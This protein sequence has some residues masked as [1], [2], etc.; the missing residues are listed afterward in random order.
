[1]ASSVNLDAMLPR[2]DF[3]VTA[4]NG[5]SSSKIQTIGLKDLTS[6][7]FIVPALRKPD[8]QRE[9]NHWSPKQISVFLK[10]FLEGELIPSLILWK[11]D[12]YIFVI[13][14]G[15]RISALRA[16][17]ED[18]YGDGPQSRLFYKNQIPAEQAKLAAKTRKIVN[19]EIGSYQE[20]VSVAKNIDKHSDFK[21]ILAKNMPAQA[22]PLL[23]VEGDADKAESSFFKINTQGT[24]LDKI[25]ERLLKN[26]RKPAA[27]A[28]RSLVRAGTGHKYWSKFEHEKK[29]QIE[30]VSKQLFE[31]LFEPETTEPLK[32]LDLPL[33]GN[34]SYGKSLDLIIDY[35]YN[36]QPT[37][38]GEKVSLEKMSDDVD[39]NLTLSSLY[40]CK[41]ITERI[42][43]NSHG[44]LGLHPAIYFYNHMGKPNKF[45]FLAVTK[46]FADAVNNNDA[47]FFKKFTQAREKLEKFLIAHKYL[48]AHI[49]SQTRSQKRISVLEGVFKFC[50]EE[51][52]QE[53][54]LSPEKI[55]D[56]AGLEFALL[57]DKEAS[58][59][60]ISTANKN[61]AFLSQALN[62]ALICPIC[63]GLISKSS[64]SYDHVVPVKKGGLGSSSNTQIT[65]PYCNTGV[66]NQQD[67]S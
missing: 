50:I 61:Q 63:K 49:V 67:N 46:M 17:V 32:T 66:K 64:I 16:W 59:A 47:N 33:G 51:V 22:L 21:A 3:A 39:G 65:H 15:H 44:S 34:V 1:M 9:T 5:L 20:L 23:W 41:T 42:T 10:S 25:E 38:Q 18:D 36:T 24:P 4:E 40:N 43:G 31:L 26:R 53:H 11:S 48:F 13:D 60:K 28:A 8:F 45:L 54:E 6:D 35:I 52:S 12:S 29:E 57:R 30:K 37:L 27:I 7:S 2:A 19:K 56:V 14:G 55:A 62:N 58:S